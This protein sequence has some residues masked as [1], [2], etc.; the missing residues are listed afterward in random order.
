MES[1]ST[2][3]WLLGRPK[4]QQVAVKRLSESDALD[5]ALIQ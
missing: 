2:T 3:E 1:S 4:W 5:E